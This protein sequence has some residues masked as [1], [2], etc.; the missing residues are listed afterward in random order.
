[1]TIANAAFEDIEA[2]IENMLDG[3]LEV[4]EPY[5]FLDLGVVLVQKAYLDARR[6]DAPEETL[7]ALRTWI[8]QA[9]HL[10]GVGDEPANQNAVPGA[11]PGAPPMPMGAGGPPGML[12]PPPP[13]VTPMP[14]IAAAP[15][16][17]M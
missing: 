17:A 16:R 5:Q 6:N 15:M 1:M 12:P 11:V 2:A 8:M 7:E 13:N 4:P 9:N 10:R 14:G 3:E